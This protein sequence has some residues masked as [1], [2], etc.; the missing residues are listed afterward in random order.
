MS[1]V[2]D[3]PITIPSNVKVVI[4]G[5]NFEAKGP[6][7]QIVYCVPDFF[8]MEYEGNILSVKPN[9][10]GK[11]LRSQVY[12]NA[13]AGTTRANLNNVVIGVSEGYEKKLSL[14]GIG[15]RGQ[16][17]GENLNLTLGFSHPVDFPIPE[18][19]SIDMPGPTEIIVKGSGKQLVGLVAAKIR[20]MRPVEPY[21]GKGIRYSD[22]KVKLKEVKK[23]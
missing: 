13:L 11:Y 9:K 23:K 12:F 4:D 21:K 20:A 17:Q 16:V 1:R 18:G 19:I 6:K 3:K 10:E 2:A 8:I 22:E 15:F 7:G 5:Q 14:V